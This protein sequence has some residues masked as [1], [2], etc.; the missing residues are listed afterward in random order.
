M[1]RVRI[2][3]LGVCL[4]LALAAGRPARAQSAGAE[5][6][7]FL[8][9]DANARAVGMGGAYTALASDS[10]ALLYNPAG[11][12]LVRRHEVTFMHNQYVE[13]MT[14]EYM[15][16][17]TRYGVGAQVN[18]LR[19][20]SLTRT[21]YSQQDGTLGHFGIDDLAVSAGYGTTFWD[22]LSL[23]VAGK[24]IRES[25]DNVT[26]SG[27]AGDLGGMFIWPDVP[28]LRLGLAV[29]N[30]GPDVTFY[31]R[32]EK[33]P[34]TCRFGAAVTF[35]DTT[36]AADFSKNRFDQP[37]ASAGVEKVLFKAMAVRL[38]F[39]SRNDADIGIS[40]GAGW[41]WKDFSVD[42][43][44]APYGDMG[45]AHRVSVTMRW[46]EGGGGASAQDETTDLTSDEKRRRFLSQADLVQPRW[47][48]R[49]AALPAEES[50]ELHFERAR[51]AIEIHDLVAARAEL[52]AAAALL[53]P[54]DRRRTLYYERMGYIAFAEGDFG[55]A[56]AYYNEGLKLAGSLGMQ[57]G[58]VADAYVGMGNCLAHEG[59]LDYAVKFYRKA[60]QV[61]PALSTRQ[62][63]D[64]TEK[65]LPRR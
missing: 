61:N 63:I 29:Q 17:A 23:G 60:F 40:G 25:N 49:R 12:G 58:S 59:D 3:T 50:P 20:G 9:L 8:S 51:R 46:G 30:L 14:Q 62:L 65:K 6:F 39:T 33:L 36:L 21:T 54:D 41:T 38:G 64:A 5:P 15:G 57:D 22:V 27:W 1:S 11:L 7:N 24:Y 31:Q 56:K 32:A 13:D 28:W 52:E 26:A 4:G 45:V 48:E 37:R 43:A 44:F 18:Y 10:N 42:Y 53:G 16:L 55:R 34:L 19:W 47:G 35:S 2:A